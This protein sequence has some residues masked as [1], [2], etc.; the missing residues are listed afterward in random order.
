M[1][2][3]RLM[4]A[5]LLALSLTV[6][7]CDDKKADPPPTGNE[8]KALEARFR[9]GVDPG[10]LH[11]RDALQPIDGLGLAGAAGRQPGDDGGNGQR[12]KGDD[13]QGSRHLCSKAGPSP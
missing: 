13:E 7:G 8:G 11:D 10:L 5:G 6:A 9:I 3:T 12:E 4:W 1:I 2:L